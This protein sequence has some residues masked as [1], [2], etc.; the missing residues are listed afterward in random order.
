M[1][2]RNRLI[3][4][5]A[6]ATLLTLGTP[7]MILM[8]SSVAAN[9]ATVSARTAPNQVIVSGFSEKGDFI[10]NGVSSV[11]FSNWST[12]AATTSGISLAN[13][14]SA[15]Y[16]FAPVAG[17]TFAVGT[18]DNVQPAASRS[19]GFPGLDVT[20]PGR[21]SGCTRLTGSF[22]IWDLAADAAGNITRLDLT[23]VEH[24][25]AGRP[26]N[27]GE[28]MINDAPHLGQLIASA[29]RIAFPDQTP[30]LP[31][32][33]SNPT[34]SAQP[35]SI[36]QSATTVSHFSV[37]PARTSCATSVAANSSCTYWLR[38]LPPKPGN[39]SATVLAVSNGSTLQVKLSGPAGGV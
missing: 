36:W 18:Y 24:C 3:N 17:E 39:Y 10:D 32:I 22:H 38:L 23:F 37:T 13:R 15:T 11:Y 27:F 2:S 12:V 9:A 19:A 5:V 25:G 33:L 14:A 4:V 1:P 7:S 31:Y 6:A 35:V 16:S 28:V 21:P 20:G 26:S 34:S 8:G 29:T 30:T